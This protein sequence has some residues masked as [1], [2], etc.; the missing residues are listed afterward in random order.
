MFIPVNL[1]YTCNHLWT[2]FIGREDIYIGITDYAER[3]LGRIELIE[4]NK[5][6]QTLMKGQSFGIIYGTNKTIDLIMPVN[7][8]ILFSN[9]DVLNHPQSLNSDSYHNWIALIT[10]KSY[11]IVK[12]DFIT[13]LDY[14]KLVVSDFVGKL[15]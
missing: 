6:G 15:N 1:K 12:N 2:R 4:I 11:K 8:Q 5:E 14:K 13:A 7:G 9:T 3:E 10:M